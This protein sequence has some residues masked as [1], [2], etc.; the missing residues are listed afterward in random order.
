[1]TG[2]RS[3][4]S[5]AGSRH[6]V[7]YYR[8]SKEKQGRSGLG[9]EA[10]RAMVEKFAAD[11][12]WVIACEFKEVQTGKGWDALDRR[13]QLAAALKE[14]RR[15]KCAVVIAKLD[16]LSRNVAFI[17]GLMEQRVPFLVVQLGP[18]VDPFMLHIYAAVA[19]KERQLISE[20]TREALAA[21]KRRGTRLGSQSL[22]TSRL[23]AGAA[24]QAKAMEAM[25]HVLPAIEGIRL[26]G[27]TTA[28][29]IAEELNRMKISTASGAPGLEWSGV[30]VSR[31]LARASQHPRQIEGGAAG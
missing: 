1:M 16:R 21:A 17:A 10:Q 7:A 3:P 30:Q 13:P 29:A 9:L 4:K 27:F 31:V 25:K 2:K 26:R 12:G 23:K 28:K 5:A 6:L 11:H 14:A 19:E 8:V 20:R 24:K 18:D 15:Q 22:S